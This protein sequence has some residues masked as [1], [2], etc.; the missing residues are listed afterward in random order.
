MAVKAVKT[1][2]TAANFEEKEA[3]ST[4]FLSLSSYLVVSVHA[5]QSVALV[6]VLQFELHALHSLLSKKYPS[7]HV[8]HSPTAE[9]SVLATHVAHPVVQASQVPTLFVLSTFAHFP[10]PHLSLATQAVSNK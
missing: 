4:H 10:S 6:H 1:A 3:F 5:L 2:P 8:L 7:V 9:P